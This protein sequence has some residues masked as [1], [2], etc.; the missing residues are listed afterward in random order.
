MRGFAQARTSGVP[1]DMFPRPLEAL[2][3]PEYA[4]RRTEIEGREGFCVRRYWEKRHFDVSSAAH[5][6]C[7]GR[8]LN[9]SFFLIHREE[10]ASP[11]P[12][13][14]A[15]IALPSRR[16]VLSPLSPRRAFCVRN[17]R[18]VILLLRFRCPKAKP[19]VR[20]NR[21]RPCSYEA[22]S[23]LHTPIIAWRVLPSGSACA[24]N[25]PINLSPQNFILGL[26]FFG[27]VGR[28][29]ARR[30]FSAFWISAAHG[31]AISP[32]NAGT[33]HANAGSSVSR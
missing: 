5:R 1:W 21:R 13:L 30:G 9:F 6:L 22:S 20:I 14:H 16:G 8:R 24:F 26:L 19:P 10:A 2:L 31:S 28:I 18:R 17:R 27:N 7:I 29:G 3:K 4:K 23:L 32:P 25:D 11:P 12:S 15:D 33:Y